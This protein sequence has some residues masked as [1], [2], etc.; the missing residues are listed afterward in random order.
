MKITEP[1]DMPR[2]DSESVKHQETSEGSLPLDY[3]WEVKVT[4]KSI[5]REYCA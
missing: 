5:S 2:R 1:S 3:A 4:E